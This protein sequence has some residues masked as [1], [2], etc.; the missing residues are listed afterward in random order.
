MSPKICHLAACHPGD[1]HGLNRRQ[2][3]KTGISMAAYLNLAR[4]LGPERAL[5]AQ[6]FPLKRKLVWINMSGGWDL[7]EVT[8]PK[9]QNKDGTS[10]LYDYSQSWQLRGG[11]TNAR[12]GRFL[13]NLA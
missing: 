8:D 11:N 3:L 6:T 4:L 7:L 9:Q 10:L 2:L 12:L 5:A 13:P 1:V